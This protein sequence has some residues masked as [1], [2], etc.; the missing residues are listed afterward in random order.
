MHYSIFILLTTTEKWLKLSRTERSNFTDATITPIIKKYSDALT[1]T[2]HDAKGFHGRHTDF[3]YIKTGSL[4]QY[5]FFWE[6]IRDTSVFSE[7]YFMV[8]DIIIGIENG[9]KAFENEYQ[10]TH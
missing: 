4:E 1:V 6:E 10:P 5:Y 9:Y 8:N 2:M 7:P 3:I